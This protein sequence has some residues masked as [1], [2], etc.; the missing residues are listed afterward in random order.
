MPPIFPQA[1]DDL[2]AIRREAKAAE[3]QRLLDEQKR[4]AKEASMHAV[5]AMREA[6]RIIGLNFPFGSSVVFE[7]HD[8]Q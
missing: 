3:Q 1:E 2:A 7:E 8:E 5:S 6:R 4:I